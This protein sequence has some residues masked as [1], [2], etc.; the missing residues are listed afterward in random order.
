MTDVLLGMGNHYYLKRFR[1][2]NLLLYMQ[3]CFLKA[4]SPL[5]LPAEET[6]LGWNTLDVIFALAASGKTIINTIQQRSP[7][8]E[9]KCSQGRIQISTM[10]SSSLGWAMTQI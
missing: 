6:G 1:I 9:G 7:Y 5:T 4:N 8:E 10:S 2:L 3:A